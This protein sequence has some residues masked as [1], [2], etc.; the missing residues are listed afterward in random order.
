MLNQPGSTLD[1]MDS[2]M[3]RFD[4]KDTI[5]ATSSIVK[6][7]TLPI[8]QSPVVFHSYKESSHELS[9]HKLSI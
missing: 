2:C 3:D 5:T 9:S 1:L 8:S 6:L 4:G 7:A